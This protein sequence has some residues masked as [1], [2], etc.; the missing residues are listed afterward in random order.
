VEKRFPGGFRISADRNPNRR[1]AEGILGAD[2]IALDLL[3]DRVGRGEIRALLVMDGSPGLDLPPALAGGLDRLFLLVVWSIRRSAW[4]EAAR[5]LFPGTAFT[6]KEGTYVN[7]D[8][9]PQTVS[10]FRQAPD[11]ARPEWEGLV[12]LDRAL[13]GSMRYGSC[14]QVL[15]DWN[16]V[17]SHRRIPETLQLEGGR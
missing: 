10:P 11:G 2:R 9:I 12:D 3:A 7:D 6:E 16:V 5:V 4:T 8:G 15:A 1:G 13:G 17:A 14:A